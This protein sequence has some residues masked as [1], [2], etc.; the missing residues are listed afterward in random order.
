MAQRRAQAAIDKLMALLLKGGTRVQEFL[1]PEV[2]QKI[3]GKESPMPVPSG[4]GNIYLPEEQATA[5]V[6]D[7]AAAM[8][9]LEELA[10]ERPVAGAQPPGDPT[11]ALMQ[12]YL[13]GEAQRGAQ[14]FAPGG[15]RGPVAESP[16]LQRLMSL[17]QAEQE[18][19][20]L[21]VDK[22][23]ELY[24]YCYPPPDANWGVFQCGS[25]KD[26]SC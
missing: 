17:P 26:Q 9:L 4:R 8:A 10:A 23:S 16:E 13:A 15:E 7:E 25:T 24:Q 20:C 3:L 12:Q 6:E 5:P 11:Q 19:Y 1:G 21:T 2:L 22:G 14:A 18:Q